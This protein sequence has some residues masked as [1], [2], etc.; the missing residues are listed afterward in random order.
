MTGQAFGQ[1]YVE[2]PGARSAW[3]R[4]PCKTGNRNLTQE[5]T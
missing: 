3:C 5:D 4:R 2:G 1:G